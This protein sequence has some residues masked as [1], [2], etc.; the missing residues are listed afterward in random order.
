MLI[1][2]KKM[3]MGKMETAGNKMVMIRNVMKEISVVTA[4]MMATADVFI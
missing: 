4:K 1:V 3:M 2:F